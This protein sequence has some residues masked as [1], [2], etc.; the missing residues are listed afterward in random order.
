MNWAFP[1]SCTNSRFALYDN[2]Q[3][4]MYAACV[5]CAKS[6]LDEGYVD[7]LMPTGT[8]VQNGR[9]TSLGDTFNRD[10]GHLDYN[11]GRY[12]ASLTWFEAITGIDATTVS[13]KPASVTEAQAV[14]CRK[15]AHDA[16]IN[17]YSVTK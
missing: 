7:M 16:N 4:K 1:K 9:Q 13:W 12:T 15:A 3:D 10:W 6:L 8:A 2:D 14:I 11:Y 17:P 5:A